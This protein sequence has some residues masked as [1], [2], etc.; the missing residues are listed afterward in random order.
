MDNHDPEFLNKA[1]EARA[2][3]RQTPPETVDAQRAAG[4]FILDVREPAEHAAGTVAGATNLPLAQLAEAIAAALPDK[5]TPVVTFC[6]G[7]NRG[8]LGADALQTL[9]Y[10]NVSTIAG[11]YR[12]YKAL[13]PRTIS[14]AEV[15]PGNQFILDV[16][17]EADHAASNEALPG[18]VWKD[19]AQI[20]SW[21]GD[22][23]RDGDVVI[24]CVR[25]GAV[26]NSV[27]DTLRAAGC[28][29][30]FIEGG[31]EAWKAAGGKPASK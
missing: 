21:Q 9:G 14:P 11:G 22:I 2:R 7:G 1:A 3:I 13:A 28:K 25:G 10:V 12:A 16:R 30:R 23:P 15:D 18:A 19:P 6:N 17:R 8:A 27:V 26:S 31:L 5:H 29:A 4:A 24:Y 20:D